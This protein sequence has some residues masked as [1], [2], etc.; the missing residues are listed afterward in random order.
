MWCGPCKAAIH[1]Y[2]YIGLIPYFNLV[3]RSMAEDLSLEKDRLI[4]WLPACTYHWGKM[5]IWRL[6]KF[7]FWAECRFGGMGESSS[8]MYWNKFWLDYTNAL[9]VPKRDVFAFVRS[10][11]V[12][13]PKFISLR[14]KKEKVWT[15]EKYFLPLLFQY[16]MAITIQQQQQHT[17]QQQQQ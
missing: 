9:K 2:L 15:E 11:R 14:A 8:N 17:Q 3:K 10:S 13:A 5:V 12:Y 7:F 4:D 16:Q 6:R 1:T